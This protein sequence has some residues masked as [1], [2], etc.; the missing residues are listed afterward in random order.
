MNPLAIVVFTAFALSACSHDSGSSGA[1][2][3]TA[4]ISPEQ[5][6]SPPPQSCGYGGYYY[7]YGCTNP[8]PQNQTIAAKTCS[9]VDGCQVKCMALSPYLTETEVRQEVCGSFF[10]QNSSGC[11]AIVS[12]N[13]DGFD[14]N[15]ACLSLKAGEILAAP[16]QIN[17]SSPCGNS[18]SCVNH[19]NRIYPYEDPNAIKTACAVSGKSGH[20]LEKV[21]QSYLAL[22][23]RK[24]CY[25]LPIA[26]IQ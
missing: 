16:E 13:R 7:G 2:S 8:P 22:V 18:S 12:I 5:A 23:Q 1:G 21:F 4:Q 24:A 9:S 14:D 3:P 26:E 6:G 20:C 11:N 10:G 25:A 19:C 17:S 15:Q